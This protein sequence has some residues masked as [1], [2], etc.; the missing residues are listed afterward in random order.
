MKKLFLVA[1][2]IVMAMSPVRDAQTSQAPPGMVL[3]PSG[4]FIM[5]NADGQDMEKPVHDVELDAFY[6]DSHEVTL[7]E[8][9]EFVDGTNYV[10]DAEKGDGSIIWTGETWGKTKGINWRFDAAGNLFFCDIGFNVVRRVDVETG[11]IT[12]VIG[13]GNGQGHSADGTPALQANLGTPHG[14]E[15]SAD[16]STVYVSDTEN[17][18][19]RCV[20]PDGLLR[21]VA[22]SDDGGDSG[23]GGP[24]TSATLN[25]PYSLRLY[26]EDILLISDHWNN[27]LRAVRLR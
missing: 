25:Y 11:V 5:G 22:G 18:Q 1:L 2:L 15:V 19:V 26:G 17:F 3:I 14:V 27:K 8:F 7:E 10:T 13:S 12:T 4:S 23:D 16:G 9:G 21:T 24:A 20:G 6:M